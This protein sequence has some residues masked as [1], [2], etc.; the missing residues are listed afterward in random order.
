MYVRGKRL[1]PIWLSVGSRSQR[2]DFRIIKSYLTF[3]VRKK[4][5]EKKALNRSFPE[6]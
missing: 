3:L 2:R 4:K 1:F 6:I 5:K